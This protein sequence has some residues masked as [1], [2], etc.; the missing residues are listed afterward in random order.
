[1]NAY[2]LLYLSLN[3]KAGMCQVNLDVSNLDPVAC[4]ELIRSCPQVLDSHIK[5]KEAR[6]VAKSCMKRIP[7]NSIVKSSKKL[8]KL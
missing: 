4:Y 8:V 2:A 7:H 5:E 1:M 6:K 3:F